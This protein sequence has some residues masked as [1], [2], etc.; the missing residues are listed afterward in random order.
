MNASSALVVADPGGRCAPVRWAIPELTVATVWRAARSAFAA[1]ADG[2]L[3]QHVK[4]VVDGD[5]VTDASWWPH[6]ADPAGDGPQ[7]WLATLATLTG[8]GPFFLWARAVQQH[9]RGLFE[10]LVQTL[11]PYLAQQGVPGGPVEAEVFFG[12]Y[13]C[14]PG[15]IHRESCAN[16]H[17]V[18][19][20]AK[21]MHFFLADTWPPADAPMRVDIAPDTGTREEYLP[22]LDPAGLLDRARTLTARAGEGFRW[23]VGTWHVAQTNGLAMALNIAMYEQGLDPIVGLHLWNGDLAGAVPQEWLARYR[24]HTGFTGDTGRLLAHLSGLAMRPAPP[25]RPTRMVRTVVRRGAAPL[26]WTA[27]PDT[28][29]LLVA[30]MGAVIRTVDTAEVRAWLITVLGAAPT[31]VPHSCRATAV[32]LYRQGILDQVEAS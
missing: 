9:H 4:L 8:G 3:P 2:R 6:R 15:G 21:S 7:R 26:L 32:W 10:A 24:A 29:A 19:E 30:G 11:A 25:V 16:L 28:G 14:T 31:A 1:E 18:V 23:S 27:E 22:T 5:F 17:L 20:G 13:R 12:D